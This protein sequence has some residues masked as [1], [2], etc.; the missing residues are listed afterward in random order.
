MLILKANSAAFSKTLA[1]PTTFKHGRF[2]ASTALMTFL[3]I[4]PLTYLSV[5]FY[6][7]MVKP[8]ASKVIRLTCMEKQ[9]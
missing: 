2:N 7:F 6:Q 4:D 1:L 5:Y 8:F 3:E 9:F